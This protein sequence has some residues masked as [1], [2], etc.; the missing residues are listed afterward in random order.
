[1][2]TGIIAALLFIGSIGF[3]QSGE[4]NVHQNG[5]IYSE[6]SVKKLRHIVDSLNLKFKLCEYTKVFKSNKQVKAHFIHLEKNKIIEAKNDIDKGISFDEFLKKYPKA[7]ADKYLLVV[8]YEYFDDYSNQNE[9][10]LSSL[11]FGQDY[12]HSIVKSKEES[13][14]IFNSD[15]KGKWYY[16][17]SPKGE[18][19]D[20]S[21][22]AFYF[23]DDF[24][25]KPIADKYSRLIQYSECMIDTSSE[26]FSEK[27][28]KA[29]RLYYDTLPRKYKDFN[30]YVEKT[31]KRPSVPD[32]VFEAAYEND[33]FDDNGKEKKLSKKEKAE[34]ERKQQKAEEKL[35]IFR[36]KLDQWESVRLV[37]TDSLKA[38]DSNFMMLL[39]EAFAESKELSLSDD[40][41][42]EYVGRYLSKE[43]ELELKRNRIVVGGC[44]M[45]QSPRIHAFNIALLSAETTKWEIF[46]RSHLNIMNDRFERSSDGSYAQA[47]RKTYIRELEVLDINVLDLIIGIS[48][49]VE[50]PSENHYYGSIDRIGRALS[51]S[52]DKEEIEKTILNMIEDDNLDDY[53]RALM[54]FLFKNYSYYLADKSKEESKEKLKSA[55][56]KMPNYLSSRITFE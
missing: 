10:H 27:A 15:V 14:G 3:S 9:I 30:S 16:E 40:E 17:Y 38:N 47:E 31:L 34:R 8:K 36:K 56:A 50:N 18:Y 53:N 29:G 46:L 23:I 13:K 41:F 55:V 51:E 19:S 20:E 42:E 45:D 21:I 2:R 11:R 22:Q 28:I 32:G 7:E 12:G 49:R 1:M 6:N 48:L 26:V 54:Y 37:R 33:F 52:N 43:N 4:F 25:S 5:L 35:E 44:S 24:V 39:K